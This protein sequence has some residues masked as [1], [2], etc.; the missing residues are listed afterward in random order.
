MQYY[1]NLIWGSVVDSVVVLFPTRGMTL[2]SGT[3]RPSLGLETPIYNRTPYQIPFL[4]QHH[5]KI[6]EHLCSLPG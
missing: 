2:L 4:A 1:K 3:E 6:E 5:R